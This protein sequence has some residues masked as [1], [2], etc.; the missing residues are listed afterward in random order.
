MKI[1]FFLF[2]LLQFSLWGKPIHCAVPQNIT[3]KIKPLLKESIDYTDKKISIK[4]YQNN[5]QCLSALVQNKVKFAVVRS[6]I[7]WE[8]QKNTWGKE[9]LKTAYITISSLPYTA[10]LYLIRSKSQFDIDLESLKGQQVSV[11][12]MGQM[13]GYLLKSLL[14]RTGISHNIQYKSIAYMDSLK[15]IEEKK[16]DAFFGFLP[17]SFVNEN[18]HFQDIFSNESTAYLEDQKLYTVDYNGIHISYTLIASKEASDEE[19]ENII[20]R[21]EEKGIFEPQTDEHFGPM[22]RYVLQHLEQ[23]QLALDA[24]V[25]E[26]SS[27]RADSPKVLSPVCLQ[28]HY[29]FL[30]LLRQKPAL[31]K[32]VRHIRTRSPAKYAEAKRYLKKIESILLNIDAEK[33]RCNIEILQEKKTTFKQVAQ[34][35]RTLGK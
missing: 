27:L 22:N 1:F 14:K 33:Q 17:S 23:I 8:L 30:D 31:K 35:L 25:A 3:M 21:L 28:Y 4:R 26:A 11:D 24:K 7:L 13:N 20:Y 29:G 2:I 9:R 16:I 5:K 18:F 12:S 32:K 15:A 6:D 34:R 19:I 10:E